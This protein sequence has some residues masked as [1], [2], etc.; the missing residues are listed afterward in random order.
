MLAF[1]IS[2]EHCTKSSTQ[3]LDK[4]INVA[5]ELKRKVIYILDDISWM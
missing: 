2:T 1:S 4:K 3:L 5:S